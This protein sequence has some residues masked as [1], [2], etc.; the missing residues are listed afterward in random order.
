MAPMDFFPKLKLR[1]A[2]RMIDEIVITGSIARSAS[3]R[4]LIYSEADY[5]VF[6][7]RRGNTLHRWGW[8]LAWR[9]GPLRDFHKICIVCTAFQ[10]A[11]AVKIWLDM[12]EGLWSY[13]G[14]KFRGSGDPH[15]F[16]A[17]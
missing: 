3:R 4:Y 15:I 8:N 13:G 12:L 7:P 10:D 16:S 11:L 2:Q 9:R 5:E 1:H 14:F 17:P 6:S